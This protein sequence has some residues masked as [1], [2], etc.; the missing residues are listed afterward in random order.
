MRDSKILVMNE[1][2]IFV[3]KELFFNVLQQQDELTLV[4]LSCPDSV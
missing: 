4:L 1:R 2:N 3:L